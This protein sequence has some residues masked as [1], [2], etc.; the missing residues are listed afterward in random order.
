MIN[1]YYLALVLQLIGMGLLKFS[2]TH[3]TLLHI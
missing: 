2:Q 3:Q 1:T